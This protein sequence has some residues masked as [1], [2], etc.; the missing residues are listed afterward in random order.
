MEMPRRFIGLSTILAAIVLAVGCQS[1]PPA[2]DS[3]DASASPNPNA[4]WTQVLRWRDD[5]N[6]THNDQRTLTAA[7]ETAALKQFF[8]ELTTANQSSLH[9]DWAPWIVIH[10]HHANGTET[11]VSSDYRI[12]RIDEGRRGDF[13]LAPGFADYIDQLFQRTRPTSP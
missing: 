3:A 12:Y 10:F 11:F 6:L 2:P 5:S 8:P 4:D 1:T 7:N 13:V 9:G